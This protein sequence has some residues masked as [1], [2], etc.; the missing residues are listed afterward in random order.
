MFL[1]Y[2][3]KL[4]AGGC[5]KE[6][7][8]GDENDANVKG[9]RISELELHNP[10]QGGGDTSVDGLA[11]VNSYH[12]LVDHCRFENV[13]GDAIDCKSYEVC[14]INTHV[15]GALC[16]SVKFWRSG[17]LINS[18]IVG[19]SAL[20]KDSE[21]AVADGPCRIVHSLLLHKGDGYS[22][23]FNYDD[24]ETTNKFEII[25]SLFSDLDYGMYY[26]TTTFHCRNSLF[27]DMPSYLFQRPAGILYNVSQL[28]AIAA[29][30]N[31][32]SAT[33]Q[34]V[35]E[36]NSD[37]SPC[38]GAPQINAGCSNGVLLPAF[39]YFGQPRVRDSAPDIG[40]I[41]YDA[42]GTDTDGDGQYDGEE[43]IAGTSALVRTNYFKILFQCSNTPHTIIWE[44]AGGRRYDL[45]S[46]TNL[47]GSWSLMAG[48][49]NLPGD[50]NLILYTPPDEAPDH[51]TKFYRVKVQ[52]IN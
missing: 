6:G 23:S 5:T 22:V 7:L 19:N 17:E 1:L 46:T 47:H 43:D 36:T 44:T 42:F 14:V 28:N 24:P 50:G 20:M 31:N 29:C 16:N 52:P 37:F 33:P 11:I 41:E 32:L 27:H 40:P 12:V 10:P 34:Y 48:M 25:N 21:I 15:E 9:L 4:V 38:Y 45:M 51:N 26:K 13:I 35:G 18:V 39:D 8:I 3:R 49:T 30:S 2:Q